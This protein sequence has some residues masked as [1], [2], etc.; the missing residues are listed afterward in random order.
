V[1]SKDPESDV[2]KI[3]YAAGSKPGQTDRHGWT[4]VPGVRTAGGS[5]QSGANWHQRTTVR[6]LDLSAKSATHLSL[7]T[8][9]GAGLTSKVHTVS[10]PFFHDPTPPAVD[11]SKVTVRNVNYRQNPS[12]LSLGAAY[13]KKQTNDVQQ[14]PGW[15]SSLLVN[16]SGSQDQVEVAVT[17]PADDKESGI[18]K[19][20]MRLL[21]NSV[22]PIT[23]FDRSS[24]CATSC[25][26]PGTNTGERRIDW[27][28]TGASFADTLYAY[29]RAT[30]R[31]RLSTTTE[32]PVSPQDR[33][34]PTTPTVR[35]RTTQNGATLYLTQRASDD[36]SSVV[37][38]QYAVGTTPYG[39][40]VRGWPSSGTDFSHRS[41]HPSL[42]RRFGYPPKSISI[43]SNEFP[44]SGIYYVT[45]R[46]VNGEG[47]VSEPVTSG[48][49]IYDTSPPLAPT[50]STQYNRSTRTLTVGAR[51]MG[52]P[53]SGLGAP[54][55][56]RGENKVS[57]QIVDLRDTTRVIREGTFREQNL[58]LQ[59]FDDRQRIFL[60]SSTA[61]SIE[62][63]GYRFVV[64]LE[65]GAGMTRIATTNTVV[66]PVSQWS[67]TAA[68][69]WRR[70]AEALRQ[71]GIDEDRI[72]TVPRLLSQ[73]APS[74]RRQLLEKMSLARTVSKRVLRRIEKGAP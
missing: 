62:A 35:V 27:S 37:G 60:S 58:E 52:D 69:F 39:T 12:N 42:L 2:T 15:A 24:A 63:Y 28:K 50:L 25:I 9:N 64:T 36:E 73:Y 57:W 66:A 17:V 44:S 71:D 13:Q 10:K 20:N 3:E 18:R 38:Y 70:A 19:Q 56:L 53:Q 68:Q 43:P 14:A 23:A 54:K 59:S 21:A 61:H 16:R 67:P 51:N 72:A 33:T 49:A 65:N 30:N 32:I 74:R 26:Q 7:R 5:G 47:D 22:A 1:R 55:N 8:T 48:P 40:D 45:V 31:A 41:L 34:R 6:D 29:V 46:A 4:Q 11:S